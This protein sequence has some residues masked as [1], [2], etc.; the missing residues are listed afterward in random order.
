[1][2]VHVQLFSILRDCLPVEARREGGIVP[3]AEGATLADLVT[4]LG[5]DRRL[6]YSPQDVVGRA[7]WQ[8]RVN[9]EFVPHVE[10]ALQEGDRVQIF[11]PVAGG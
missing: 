5:I 1:M 9:D 11:P 10:R 7:G 4:H 6:G 8:V 3:L 2:N